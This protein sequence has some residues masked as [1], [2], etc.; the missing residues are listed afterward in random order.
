MNLLFFILFVIENELRVSVTVEADCENRTQVAEKL[1]NKV[2]H[3]IGLK[4]RFIQ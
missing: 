2:S 3:L 1:V 4:V